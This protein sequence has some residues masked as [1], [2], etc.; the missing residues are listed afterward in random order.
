MPAIEF[1]PINIRFIKK[2]KEKE[3]IDLRC[4]VNFSI[5]FTEDPLTRKRN[6]FQIEWIVV[7]D[8]TDADN[9]FSTEATQN[10]KVIPYYPLP[11]GEFERAI[12]YSWDCLM[13]DLQKKLNDPLLYIQLLLTPEGLSGLASTL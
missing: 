1:S 13:K 9:P 12:R 4:N 5:A 10:I 7:P 11:V 3:P 6:G 8:D 2:Q